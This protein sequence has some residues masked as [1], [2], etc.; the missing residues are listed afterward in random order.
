MRSIR[1]AFASFAAVIV[2]I[3]ALF[4]VGVG[5]I[6]TQKGGQIIASAFQS[7]GVLAPVP[8]L[9]RATARPPY[10]TAANGFSY[11]STRWRSCYA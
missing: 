4:A 11:R 10:A 6:D 7:P 3:V 5:L 2:A 9:N 1:T 8:V